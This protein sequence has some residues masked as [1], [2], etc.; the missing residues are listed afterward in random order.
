MLLAAR[1][2]TGFEQRITL[3]K[4]V[5]ET[6]DPSIDGTA[7]GRASAPN[8]GL[9]ARYPSLSGAAIGTSMLPYAPQA[10]RAPLDLR[11]MFG[12]FT[13]GHLVRLHVG[14]LLVLH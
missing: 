14:G 13:M 7:F 5:T 2:I 11:A 12:D 4:Y 1:N 6:I 3:V 8:L 9:A 10:S